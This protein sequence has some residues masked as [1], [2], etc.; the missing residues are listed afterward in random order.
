MLFSVFGTSIKIKPQTK[1]LLWVIV[2]CITA[3]FVHK[4]QAEKVCKKIHINIANEY[5]NYFVSKQDITERITEAGKHP[6]VN[7]VYDFISLKKLESLAATHGFIQ[8]AVVY[9]DLSGQLHL[10]I[11]QHKPLLRIASPN[12]SGKYVGIHGQILPL[13]ERFTPRLMVLTG[14]YATILAQKNWA[15]D[16]LRK[17]YLYLFEKIYTDEFLN[18]MLA[19]AYVNTKGDI[20]FYPQLGKQ[21][22]EFGLPHNVDKK[23][24]AIKAFYKKIVPVKGWNRYKRINLEYEN[25][26]ICE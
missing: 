16:S 2:M 19:S 23:L 4:R 14:P 21:V 12:G 5:N 7:T 25:Q 17:P 11:F 24:L 6:I 9:T 20:Y 18:T 15:N 13:S 10:Q 8:K 26:L 22:I 3:A 1:A